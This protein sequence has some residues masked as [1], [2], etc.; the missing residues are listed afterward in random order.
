MSSHVDPSAPLQGKP[1]KSTER[2]LKNEMRTQLISFVFMIFITSMAFLSIAS[3]AVPSGFAIPF[4][5]ILASVQVI[6]QL[7]FFMH[8]NA[9][10]TGWVNVMIWSGLFVAALTVAT[11][12]LLIGVVKY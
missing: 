4:I 3:D 8:M 2:K 10:G 12:M 11:L 7:Y 1:S 9:K 5:L 6:L